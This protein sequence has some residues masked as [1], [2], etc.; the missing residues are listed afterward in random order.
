MALA[1]THV[2]GR[3][4]D[5]NDRA[6]AASPALAHALAERLGRRAIT[7]GEPEPALS[8]NWDVELAAAAPLFTDLAAR[9]DRVLAAGDIPV[10]ALGR[11]APAIATLPVVARRRPDAVVLWFDAHGDL[12]APENSETGYLGGL[13]LSGPLGH[14]QSGFGAGLKAANVILVGSRDLDPPERELVVNGTIALVSVGATMA[15][16]LRCAIV[17][18]RRRIRCSARA[19]AAP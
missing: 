8:A 7:I 19:H 4:G 17:G 9:I 14:W 10:T 6:M 15:E 3:V 5:H 13:A 2:A 18:R 1:L 16:D 11:C 12:N